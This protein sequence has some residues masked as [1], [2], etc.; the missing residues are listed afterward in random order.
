MSGLRPIDELFPGLNRDADGFLDLRGLD[1]TGMNFEDRSLNWVR[2]GDKD[3]GKPALLAGVSFRSS[4][5]EVVHFT[6][7]QLERNDFRGAEVRGCDFRYISCTRATFADT[8]IVDCDFYRAYFEAST[9]FSKSR[10]TRVSLDKA[11]L[12]GATDLQRTMFDE[13]SAGP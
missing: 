12:Q 3:E 13:P 2:F 4:D 7:A 1:L 6:R 5:L 8:T 11:W 10:L 9:L